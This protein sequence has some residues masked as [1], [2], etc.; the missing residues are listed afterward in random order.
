MASGYQPAE[1]HNDTR[2]EDREDQNEEE[3][4]AVLTRALPLNDVLTVFV[5]VHSVIV[6][7]A[8]ATDDRVVPSVELECQCGTAYLRE[9]LLIWLF[10]C[11]AAISNPKVRLIAPTRRCLTWIGLA[12]QGVLGIWGMCLVFANDCTAENLKLFLTGCVG[13]AASA[14]IAMVVAVAAYGVA[15][16]ACGR[17]Q[18]TPVRV[19]RGLSAPFV[20][21]A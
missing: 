21:A 15:A 17:I 7:A 11:T 9:Y 10:C 16:W 3:P 4:S 6:V 14:S 18:P 13:A 2:E 5:Y 19:A 20:A 12:F 8:L 1:D